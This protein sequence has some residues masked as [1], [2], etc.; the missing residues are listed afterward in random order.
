MVQVYLVKKCRAKR[1]S[2]L[3][4]IMISLSNGVSSLARVR[5]FSLFNTKEVSNL[6]LVRLL[7]S[8]SYLERS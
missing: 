4:Q 8:F 5:L 2:R 3:T 6:A 1:E 7:A